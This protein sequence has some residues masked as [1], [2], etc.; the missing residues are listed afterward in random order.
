[1]KIKTFTIIAIASFAVLSVTACG[2]KQKAS[3]ETEQTEETSKTEVIVSDNKLFINSDLYNMSEEK[4][5]FNAHGR[6]DPDNP[7]FGTDHIDH[8]RTLFVKENGGLTVGYVVKTTRGITLQTGKTFYFY[9]DLCLKE[10]TRDLYNIVGMVKNNGVL[11]PMKIT[12]DGED[13][14]IMLECKGDET[15]TFVP[16]RG[17]DSEIEYTVQALKDYCHKNKLTIHA[18]PYLEFTD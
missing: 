1:M 12:I 7:S 17:D 2:G 10:R 14:R 3:I 18:V 15:L 8:Y 6:L 5:I 4:V 16:L 11:I 9:N 13:N